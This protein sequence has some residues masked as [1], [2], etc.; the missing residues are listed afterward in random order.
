MGKDCGGRRVGLFGPLC[1]TR[2]AKEVYEECVEPAACNKRNPRYYPAEDPDQ[3]RCL[4][5]AGDAVGWLYF[6]AV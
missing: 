1:R 4:A 6:A 2:L 3:I 5:I